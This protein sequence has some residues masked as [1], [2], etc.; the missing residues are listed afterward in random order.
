MRIDWFGLAVLFGGMLAGSL[1]LA[2]ESEKTLADRIFG[3]ADKDNDG[4]LS[5]KEV[6]EAKRIFKSAI[7]EKKKADDLPG[8]K[9]TFERIEN[10]ATQGKVDDNKDGKVGKNEWLNYV[11]DGFK[12]KEAIL[13][14]AK[15]KLAAA[16]KKQEN[17]AQIERLRR[18][19]EQLEKKLRQK[20]KKK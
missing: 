8:G 10:A 9:A 14:D 19:K 4:S 12:K 11:K 1:A 13:K 5:E 2:D 15:E 20:K 17:Q 6:P 18:E 16:R 7:F 3:N